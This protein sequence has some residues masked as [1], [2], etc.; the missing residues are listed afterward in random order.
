[1]SHKGAI[2]V[3]VICF[4]GKYP[5][6]TISSISLL[7]SFHFFHFLGDPDRECGFLHSA[8]FLSICS[9]WQWLFLIIVPWFHSFPHSSTPFL[10]P[11]SMYL[12]PF[13][14][15]LLLQSIHPSSPYPLK[16]TPV[17]ALCCLC[18]ALNFKATQLF[19]WC[20]KVFVIQEEMQT[21]GACGFILF[22]FVFILFFHRN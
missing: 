3:K 4:D 8:S 16:V 15:V 19:Q 7:L 22:Y 18:V 9:F 21:S 1:M 14:P 2:C 5:W 20:Y 13:F 12:F 17:F 11:F 10:S 6:L